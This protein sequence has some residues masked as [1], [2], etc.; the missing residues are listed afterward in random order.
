[1]TKRYNLTYAMC[2]ICG[3][4]PQTKNS[5]MNIGPVHYWDPDDG[6]IVGALC[7]DCNEEFGNRQPQEHDF[8]Y[9]Q[10]PD[11]ITVE[12]DEDPELAFL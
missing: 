5:E 9:T 7:R 4:Q 3:H 1:M 6:W 8:A 11:R 10:H 12:T 2:R